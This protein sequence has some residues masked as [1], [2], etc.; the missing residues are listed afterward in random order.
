MNWHD[1]LGNI[2]YALIALS[3]LVTNMLWLRALAIAGLVAESIYFYL[4]G[5]A[6]LWVAIGWSMVFLLIN[7]VQLTRLLREMRS[8]KLLADERFLRNGTLAGL[9][10]LSFHRLMRAGRWKT[11][12]AG[13]VLTVQQEAVTHLQLLTR[14]L[15]SVVV[16]GLTVA[17]IRPGGIVGEMSLLTG[18]V[19]SATVTLAEE[20]HLFELEGSALRRLLQEH[21]ELQAQFH[22]VLGGELSAKLLALRGKNRFAAGM[23]A[24]SG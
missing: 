14:G 12:P 24:H 6:S 21:D 15:A 11:L 23:D 10:Q 8:S 1:G 7:A 16:D 17:H 4:V 18:D 22:Q 9:S 3:Y 19:A 5:S 20:A 13:T 2:S